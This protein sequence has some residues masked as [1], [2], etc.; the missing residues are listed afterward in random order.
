[1]ATPKEDFAFVID[2]AARKGWIV[3]LAI[4]PGPPLELAP[5]AVEDVYVLQVQPVEIGTRVYVAHPGHLSLAGE[6][7]I[8]RGPHGPDPVRVQAFGQAAEVGGRVQEI[9]RVVKTKSTSWFSA[10]STNGEK[11]STRPSGSLSEMMPPRVAQ[12]IALVGDFDQDRWRGLH[13]PRQDKP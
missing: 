2:Q 3:D 1:M 9:R 11:T 10:S 6:H 8:G 5:G 7:T 13:S 4:A 12:R